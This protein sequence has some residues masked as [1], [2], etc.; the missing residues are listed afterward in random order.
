MLLGLGWAVAGWL[1]GQLMGCRL[2]QQ[3]GHAHRSSCS[4]G[5]VQAALCCCCS[6]FG[7]TL[8]GTCCPKGHPWARSTS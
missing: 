1:W 7:D 2:R 8:R 6:G 4:Q 3:D 5:S